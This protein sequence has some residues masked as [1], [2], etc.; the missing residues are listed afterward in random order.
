MPLH[1]SSE[2]HRALELLEQYHT[3]LTRPSDAELKYAI[4]RVINMFKSN[5]F[6]ALCGGFK[7]QKIYC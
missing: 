5:L 2:A 4:E 7:I 3:L 6:Q 1:K